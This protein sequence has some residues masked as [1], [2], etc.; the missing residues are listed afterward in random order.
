MITAATLREHILT[1]A[2]ELCL[3]LT[4][5]HANQLANHLAHQATLPAPEPGHLTPT[6]HEALI[7]LAAGEEIEETSRRLCMPADTVK[8]RRRSLY[9]ALGAKNGAHAVAIAISL[10][11][12]TL[13]RTS[14]AVE[15][16]AWAD[17]VASLGATA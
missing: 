1:A 8:S 3:P 13:P 15:D 12:L 16:A 17:A 2:D 7:A 11:I 4:V 6:Q 10:G 9:K 5:R 14:T